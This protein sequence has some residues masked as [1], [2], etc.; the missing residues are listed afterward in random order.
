MTCFR[1]CRDFPG[2]RLNRIELRFGV[3]ARRRL[4]V[5]V[6]SYQLKK[7]IVNFR[8]F[9]S[10]QSWLRFVGRPFYASPYLN[11]PRAGYKTAWRFCALL[12]S[13]PI[14]TLK[15]RSMYSFYRFSRWR[16]PINFLRSRFAKHSFH[17]DDDEDAFDGK[18]RWNVD[19][20]PDDVA[21]SWRQQKCEHSQRQPGIGSKDFAF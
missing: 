5:P 1:E 19:H 14:S 18:R 3:Q 13:V 10:S 20:F 12:G 9:L 8:D 21:V 16:I 2:W 17:G 11:R 7:Q 6:A 4:P 15:I